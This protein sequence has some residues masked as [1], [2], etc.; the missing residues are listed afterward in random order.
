MI[1]VKHPLRKGETGRGGGGGGGGG[2]KQK[3]NTQ[4]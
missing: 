4:A 3:G 1:E 2:E